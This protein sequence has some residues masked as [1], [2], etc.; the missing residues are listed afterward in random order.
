MA[1]S[2]TRKNWRF[3]SVSV[4]VKALFLRISGPNGDGMW[5]QLFRSRNIVIITVVAVVNL[6]R[7]R[8]DMS[9]GPD[10]IVYILFPSQFRFRNNH[11]LRLSG[12][13]QMSK[14]IA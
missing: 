8:V 4:L 2:L 7:C 13:V 5:M 3:G 1:L 6:L 12:M 14:N 9:S 10:L 11:S